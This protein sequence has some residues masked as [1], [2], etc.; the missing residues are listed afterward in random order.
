MSDVFGDFPGKLR[1]LFKPSRYKILYGGRGGAKSWG[2]ARALLLQGVDRPLRILCARETQKSISDSVHYLLKGQIEA[3]GLSGFYNVLKSEITGINETTFIFA[4]IRQNVSNIK[5]YESVDICWVEEAQNVSKASWEVLVPTIRKPGSEIWVSFNPELETDDTYKRFVISPPPNATVVRIGWRDNPWFPEVLRQEME[6]LKE[7]DP[8]AYEHVWEGTC[9][10]VVEG[11]VYRSELLAA[12]KAGRICRVPYDAS[13]PVDTFWDLGYFDNVA[14]WLAQSV[15]FEFRFIDF[16]QGSQQSLQ[17]YLRELQQRPYVYGTD[18]L[19]W[20][21]GTPSLQTG[22]SI[23]DQMTAAGR[24]VRVMP[25]LKVEQGIQAA[26]TIFSKCYFDAEKCADGIQALRHYRYEVDEKLGSLRKEPLHDWASHA[27]DAFRTAAVMIREP[28]K[29][30]E[31]EKRR[32]QS[33]LSPW[34]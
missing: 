12:D 1:P 4:G 16:I 3:L 30:K 10:Q 20:D 26:R 21:G 24:R 9:K 17:Y 18:T 29:K 11:A 33:K 6:H 2:I 7:R 32:T 34:S 15:G 13:K 5:S 27:A 23:R 28:E 8:D 31:Q 19:P 22:R 25:Q 14:I